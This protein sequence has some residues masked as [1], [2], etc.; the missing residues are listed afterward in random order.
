[1]QE[2]LGNKLLLITMQFKEKFLIDENF[3]PIYCE[4]KSLSH[5]Q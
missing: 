3:V 5:C 4:K 1:M 2:I